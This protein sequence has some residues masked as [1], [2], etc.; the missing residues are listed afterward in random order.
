M[1]NRVLEGK[2]SDVSKQAANLERDV[3]V[4]LEVID[5][6]PGARMMRK[7]A[8]PRLNELTEKDFEA[9]GWR[10]QSASVP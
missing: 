2:W 3:Q 4:R 9:A 10:G 7:G 1:A 5:A 6:K 8:F